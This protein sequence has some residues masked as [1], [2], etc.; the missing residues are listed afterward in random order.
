VTLTLA[1]GLR[2]GE[3]SALR[4]SDVDLDAGSLT[5]RRALS[6]V[7]GEV[8]F[9]EPKTA[10][11]RRTVAIPASVIGV[12]RT[13]RKQQAEDQLWAGSCWQDHGLI[14]TSSIG[15]P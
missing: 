7:A 1:T 12:L 3:A 8:R 9:E 14:F 2:Q 10:R 6:R 4:W 13:H 15:R 5:I 11:S